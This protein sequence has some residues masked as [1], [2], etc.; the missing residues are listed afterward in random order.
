MNLKKLSNYT[1]Y[2]YNQKKELEDR[3]CVS[4]E[5]EISLEEALRPSVNRETLQNFIEEVYHNNEISTIST[6]VTRP[7]IGRVTRTERVV[8]VNLS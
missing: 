3:P 2:K 4:E 8:S 1:E 5:S 7:I 6:T